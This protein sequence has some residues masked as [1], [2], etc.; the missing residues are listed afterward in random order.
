M[1]PAARKTDTTVHGGI[2][3]EGCASTVFVNN[4]NSAM[5]TSYHTCP[6]SN[7]PAP[8][9]GGPVITSSSN[10]IIENHHAARLGD[11]ATCSGPPD[12]IQTGSP[13]VFIGG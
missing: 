2:I 6:M 5:L 1:P 13:N 9:V 4:L 7:G 3:T 8:H 10:V 12:A 11:T